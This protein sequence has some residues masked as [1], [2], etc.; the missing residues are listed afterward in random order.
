LG[1][2]FGITAAARVA[3]FALVGAYKNV[4]FKLGHT[5]IIEMKDSFDGGAGG[6]TPRLIISWFIDINFSVIAFELS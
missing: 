6:D 4:F 1:L 3:E 2:P 5:T